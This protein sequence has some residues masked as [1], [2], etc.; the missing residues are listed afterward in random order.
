MTPRIGVS[1]CLLGTQVRFDGGHARNVF[2]AD[3]LGPLVEWV[4][5]CPE[6]EAGLGTPRETIRLVEIDGIRRARTTRSGHDVTDAL[7]KAADTRVEVLATANLSGFV[8]K[9]DS[10]S[11]GLE[12]VRVY[13][14][15]GGHT[16]AGR[17]L[18]AE[19]LL[20]RL[21]LLPVEEEGRLE[22][23]VLRDQF[24]TRVFAYQRLTT[25]FRGAWSVGTLVRFH[26]GQKLALM[27][28]SP[29]GYRELGRVVAAAAAQPRAELADGYMRRF[30]EIVGVAP[31][32]G[33]HVNV[34]Q[35][36]VG[37]FTRELDSGDRHEIHQAID[38]YVTG[39]IPLVVPRALCHHHARRH[40]RQWLLDQSYFQPYP[41][42]LMPG[43]AAV[44]T[45]TAGRLRA[46]SA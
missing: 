4:P 2:V 46:A 26:S 6:V 32:P 25:L 35:H 5:V 21:P 10:P 29:D 41:K 11:C 39:C 43:G 33:R 44:A 1:A 42:A 13:H 16:R 38:D 9:K 31:T 14:P 12:R 34:L 18:F 30:M 17:G 20:A 24:L 15:Q 36:A 3:A 40:G 22:D 28:H 19:A 27:A 45:R 37:Y 7:Q 23:P 8:L